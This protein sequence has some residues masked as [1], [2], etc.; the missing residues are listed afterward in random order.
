MKIGLT[1]DLREDYNIA[2]DSEVFADFCH[3]DEIGYLSRAIEANGHQA[4]ML[5]NMY[6]LNEAI[7]EKRFDCDLVFVEDEGIASRNREAIVP[8]LLELN[9]IPY[10]GSDAYAIGLSQ[11]KYHTKLVA[12]SLGIPMPKDVYIPYGTE[13]GEIPKALCKGMEQAG[14]GFPIVVKPNCEGYS[15]GV[16][17]ANNLKEATEKVIANF[18]NYHQEVLCEEYIEGQELYVPVIGSGRESRCLGTGRCTYLDGSN[19]TIFSLKDKCF[20]P[21]K[22]SMA[23]LPESVQKGLFRWSL[24][25]HNH[26]GCRD[27]SRSD[28]R[29]GKDGPCFLEIN[30]RP[31]LTENGPFETCGKSLGMTYV[32][33]IGKIIDSAV[34]RYPQ[35][36]KLSSP[37]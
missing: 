8:A 18:E 28:F 34:K 12:Q 16:F 22:D 37:Q 25:L 4:V 6:K 19:F 14:I 9:K 27:F 5:G 13:Y 36:Q 2:Q 24:E 31:G 26:L 30:P 17:L 11:N 10:V 1:Y 21:L 35:L 32:Q 23:E 33:V 20:T 7:R 3:P 29:M 15:M